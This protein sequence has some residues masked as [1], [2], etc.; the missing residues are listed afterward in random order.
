LVLCQR[1]TCFI[2]INDQA[3]SV[4]ASGIHV[5]NESDV[6]RILD[7]IEAGLSPHARGSLAQRPQ[8]N[9]D[10]GFAKFSLNDLHTLCEERELPHEYDFKPYRSEGYTVGLRIG[11]DNG[12]LVFFHTVKCGTEYDAQ[13]A[14]AWRAY[15]MMTGRQVRKAKDFDGI[16][17]HEKLKSML[18]ALNTDPF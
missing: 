10:D 11:M 17:H 7:D 13:K 1:G 15:Q 18:F 12:K 6:T 14:V 5:K 3:A 9:P 8:P 16:G 4:T 2:N